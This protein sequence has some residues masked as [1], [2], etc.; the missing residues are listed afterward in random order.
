MKILVIE[1]DKIAQLPKSNQ[2]AF[3]SQ[4]ESTF[5]QNPWYANGQISLERIYKDGKEFSK[6][7]DEV[8]N[9]I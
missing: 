6:S 4:N 8:G 1:E 9:E 7:W 3:L 2:G 5:L